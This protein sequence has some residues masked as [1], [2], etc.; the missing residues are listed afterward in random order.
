VPTLAEVLRQ[1]PDVPMLIDIKTPEAQ[2]ALAR[3]LE[4]EGAVE[5]SVVA[6]L[7]SRALEVFR[8]P[9]FLVGGSRRDIVRLFAR[10]RLGLSTAPPRSV[11]LAVPDYWRGIEVPRPR[12]VAEARRHGPPVHVWTVDDP[13]RAAVL[14]MRGVSG[15]IT[16]RPGVMR[17]GLGT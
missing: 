6:S 11:L 4:R 17:K 2:E 12:F 10:S 3:V 9:P 5:R 15:I 8:R 16:N 7:L 1:F 14:R 13:A